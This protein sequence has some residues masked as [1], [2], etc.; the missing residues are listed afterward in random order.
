MI[1]FIYRSSWTTKGGILE[2]SNESV[3]ME[4]RACEFFVC[5]RIFD[6][7][8]SSLRFIYLMHLYDQ[9]YS[10]VLQFV[11]LSLSG[12]G[13]LIFSGYKFFTRGKNK[14]KVF[15]S[16]CL[17]SQWVNVVIYMIYFIKEKKSTVHIIVMK[18]L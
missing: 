10:C 18:Q 2:R 14:D 4:G 6:C 11:I 7:R 15:P 13:L 5:L 12:W 8:S 17:I 16:L 1:L 3:T 9:S